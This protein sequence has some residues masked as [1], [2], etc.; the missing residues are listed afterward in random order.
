MDLGEYIRKN[1]KEV[2]QY[3][4]S[5]FPMYHQ[6][7]FFFR[8]VQYGI[9]AMFREKGS[10]VRSGVAE[11]LA[12]D[13]VTEAVREEIF[14]PMDGQTWR[15]NYPEFKTPQVKK[16][17]SRPAPGDAAPR[18]AGGAAPKPGQSPAPPSQS[19]KGGA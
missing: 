5:R 16:A 18:P 8:D 7:N 3:L 11:K 17:P 13:F 12:R 6:S 15:V 19:S 14:M 1:H 10:K 2:L 9:Q 4:K